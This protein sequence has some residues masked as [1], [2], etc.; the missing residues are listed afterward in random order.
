[1]G[2][3]Q[4][5]ARCERLPDPMKWHVLTP[6]LQSR[7]EAWMTEGL[8]RHEFNIVPAHYEH[9]PLRARA[10]VGHWADFVRQ[11][12]RAHRESRRHE[13]LLT[14]F[15]PL[16]LTSAALKRVTFR[17]GPLVA[18]TFNL[19]ELYGGLKQTLA[20]QVAGA[21]DVFVVHSR[22]EVARYSAWLG[23]PE[24]RF[25]YVP[26]GRDLQDPWLDEDRERPFVLAMGS[27]NRDWATLLKA[28]ERLGLR[29]VIVTPPRTLK[30]LHLPPQVELLSGLSLQECRVLCQR[31]TLNVVPIANLQTASGQ[32]ALTEAMMMGR[33]VVA[34]RCPGTEDIVRDGDTGCLVPAGDPGALAEQL[35]ALWH[36]APRRARLGAAARAH[37]QTHL[38]VAAECAQMQAVLD[39]WA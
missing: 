35:Q 38:S 29:T 15:P 16:A 31:A 32:V 4:F 1:M 18:W 7:H 23:L 5:Q 9:D 8:V 20:R 37:V 3:A 39:R 30:G 14:A 19:G 27:A 22:Q 6:F 13:G 10:T 11:T 21:V 28:V 25:H 12:A 34:T 36:D 17:R 26:L 33:A 2:R 24:D